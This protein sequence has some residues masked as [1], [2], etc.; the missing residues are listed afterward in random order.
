M[1]VI[2]WSLLFSLDTYRV[3]LEKTERKVQRIG[4]VLNTTRSSQDSGQDGLSEGGKQGQEDMVPN[5]FKFGFRKH[6]EIAHQ[7]VL[8][9]SV[10]WQSEPLLTR[11]P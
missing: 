2:A 11:L 7:G 5:V 10:G 9:G 1:K 3:L 8:E 4:L 6:F